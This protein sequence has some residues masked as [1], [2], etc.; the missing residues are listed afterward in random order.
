LISSFILLC[1]IIESQCEEK[2]N[3]SASDPCESYTECDTCTTS[4]CN[5]CSSGMSGSRCTSAKTAELANCEMST[6]ATD[7]FATRVS[8]CYGGCTAASDCRDCRK[9]PGCG[10]CYDSN[11]C[12]YISDANHTTHDH[13]CEVILIDSCD[14]PCVARTSCGQCLISPSCNWC[15]T[16]CIDKNMMKMQSFNTS[17]C[18]NS[19]P[20]D[21][22]TTET[23]IEVTI[24]ELKTSDTSIV[25]GPLTLIGVFGTMLLLAFIYIRKRKATPLPANLL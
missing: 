19:C 6:C 14:I 20:V 13:Y 1:L 10:W 23:K 21:K 15:G 17:S 5:W 11:K 12:L 16:S 4:E 2:I 25:R 8:D 7:L 9:I 24:T 3:L 18:V 22:K